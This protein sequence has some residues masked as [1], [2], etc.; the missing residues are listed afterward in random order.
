MFLLF[1]A[2]SRTNKIYTGSQTGPGYDPAIDDTGIDIGGA[3]GGG[4]GGG[5][6][7][8]SVPSDETD[9]PEALLRSAYAAYKPK[10]SLASLH[11]PGSIQAAARNLQS[12]QVTQVFSDYE[13]WGRWKK[14]ALY[15]NDYYICGG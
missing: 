12:T 9:D 14:P 13:R 3:A 8:S 7:G 11:S 10:H 2:L 4:G 1:V 6:G 15:I 5:G